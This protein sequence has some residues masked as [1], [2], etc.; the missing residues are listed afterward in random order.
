MRLISS[1]GVDRVGRRHA[2]TKILVQTPMINIFKQVFTFGV[3][4]HAG[5]VNSRLTPY[6]PSFLHRRS[7]GTK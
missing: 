5:D 2:H 1:I 3:R 7:Q 4:L 6:V